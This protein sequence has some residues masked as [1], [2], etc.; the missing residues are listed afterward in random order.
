MAEVRV[1]P[2]GETAPPGDCGERESAAVRPMV[3][4]RNRELTR[5][6]HGRD[7]MRSIAPVW[8]PEAISSG[9]HLSRG[10]M[11]NLAMVLDEAGK[12]AEDEEE[13]ATLWA[14][15]PGRR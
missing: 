8:T 7:K 13:T 15:L 4:C 14:I 11:C 12:T 1:R 2:E 10:A 5:F 9:T 6:G 3:R